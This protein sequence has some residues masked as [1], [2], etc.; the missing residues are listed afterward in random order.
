MRYLLLVDEED[1]ASF[2][3]HDKDGKVRTVIGSESINV[4]GKQEIK[5]E[6][7]IMFFSKEGNLIEMLPS[8]K[9]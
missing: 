7:N 5:E 2:K 4:S 1:K 8:Q 9:K 3:I 6:S